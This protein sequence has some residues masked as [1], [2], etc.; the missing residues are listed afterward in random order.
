MLKV[1]QEKFE[2]RLFARA[3]PLDSHAATWRSAEGAHPRPLELIV[4][5]DISELRD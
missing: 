3:I 5:L 4:D 1:P 2:G